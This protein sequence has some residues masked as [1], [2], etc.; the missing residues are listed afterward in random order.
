M[1][2]PPRPR[3]SLRRWSATR[4]PLDWHI[5]MGTLTVIMLLCVIASPPVRTL[6]LALPGSLHQLLTTTKPLPPMTE[7]LFASV[8]AVGVLAIGHAEGN[9]TVSGDRTSLYWGHTDP[10]NFRRNQGWCSDQGRGGG[11]A[12]RAD[13]KCLERVQQRL[14]KLVADLESAGLDPGVHIEVFINAV[15]LYNQASP[16]VSV[17]FPAQY[18]AARAQGKTGE[19]AIVW[20][21]VEAFR[22]RDRIDASGLIGICRRENRPV[23]DWDCVAQDQRRRAQAIHRVLE[24]HTIPHGN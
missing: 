18:A 23:S 20:A 12:N 6:L 11:D 10:G 24:H 1:K 9:L 3:R 19:M 21:R 7:D 15:D 13:Q 17:Q 16:W 8:D 14:P 4:D 22:R 5:A 2:R